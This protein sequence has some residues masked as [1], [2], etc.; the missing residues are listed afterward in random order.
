MTA[1]ASRQVEDRRLLNETGGKEGSRPSRRRGAPA[2]FHVGFYSGADPSR[3]RVSVQKKNKETKKKTSYARSQRRRQQSHKPFASCVAP[4][5]RFLNALRRHRVFAV[6]GSHSHTQTLDTRGINIGGI[7]SRHAFPE[8][9]YPAGLF[10]ETL[11][12]IQMCVCVKR[13]R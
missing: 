8:N 7:I 10:D 4:L 12:I 9:K 1:S 2:D 6:V 13:E 5:V 3:E 11:S